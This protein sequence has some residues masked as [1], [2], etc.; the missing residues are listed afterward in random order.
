MRLTSRPR[1]EAGNVVIFILI[2]IGLFAALAYTFMRG[3]APGQKQ[4]TS[5]QAR[6][7]AQELVSFFNAVDKAAN[8][9]RSRGCSESDISFSNPNDKDTFIALNDSPTAPADKSCHI[10][11]AAGAGMNMTM[12]WA[13]YQLPYESFHS[14]HSHIHGQ[15]HLKNK[16]YI[17]DSG[18]ADYNMA[19]ILDYLKPEICE[20]YN[21]ILNYDIDL[22]INDATGLSPGEAIGLINTALAGKTTACY[23]RAGNQTKL[24]YVWL[25]R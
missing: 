25:E 8:K 2:G 3:G 13:R 15:I 20:A 19:I 9:L 12:D 18:S 4:L 17:A 1:S 14:V 10:F 5:N 22:S 7:A 6:M 21:K 24:F 11:D 23:S 16:S